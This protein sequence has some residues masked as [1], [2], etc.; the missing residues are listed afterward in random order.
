[1]VRALAAPIV[2]HGIAT[3]EELGLETFEARLAAEIAD[4]GAV[5]LPPCVAGAWGL[6]P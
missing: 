6:R 4:A 2:A 1:V 5:V 3:E